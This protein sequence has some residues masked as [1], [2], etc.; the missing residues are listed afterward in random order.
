MKLLSQENKS[1]FSLTTN[2]KKKVIFLPCVE[3]VEELKD[4]GE[5]HQVDHS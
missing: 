4:V 1:V 2:K 3:D 5:V